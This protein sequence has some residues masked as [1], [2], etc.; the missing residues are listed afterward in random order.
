MDLIMF[1]TQEYENSLCASL[2]PPLNNRPRISQKQ[3][4]YLSVTYD[5]LADIK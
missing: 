4:V 2:R 1:I 5:W 3:M